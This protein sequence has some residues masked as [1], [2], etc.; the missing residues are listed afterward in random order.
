MS[1]KAWRWVC[2]ALSVPEVVAFFL[3]YA[4]NVTPWRA[5]LY[6]WGSLSI[7]LGDEKAAD[8]RRRLRKEMS[9]EDI[10][11]AEELRLCVAPGSRLSLPSR[12]FS[13]R[14]A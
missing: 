13:P 9:Q 1:Q 4:S 3:P 6:Q 5:A 2:V 7:A 10:S 12:R 8:Y 14:A 11:R